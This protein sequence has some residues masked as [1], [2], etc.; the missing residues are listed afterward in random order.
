MPKYSKS[1]R[2]KLETAHPDFTTLMNIVIQ[3]FDNSIIYG[4]RTPAL[5]FKLFQQGRELQKGVWVKVGDTVTNC[6]GY[7]ILSP[8]NVLPLSDAIDVVPWPVDWKNLNRMRYFIGFVKGTAQIL[9]DIGAIENQIV[10]GM[11]WDNDTILTDQR[12]FDAPHLQIK[13]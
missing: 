12:F 13:R 11:D 10:S 9:Y 6:D 5:Q 4:G 3:Y 8:H 2:E 1:S 7:D